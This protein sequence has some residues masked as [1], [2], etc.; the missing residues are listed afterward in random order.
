M[1]KK[2][3][4]TQG[5]AWSWWG[6]LVGVILG[7]VVLAWPRAETAGVTVFNESEKDA[8]ITWLRANPLGFFINCQSQWMRHGARC[9]H[10]SEARKGNWPMGPVKACA[11][12]RDRLAAYARG[13]Q[14]DLCSDCQRLGYV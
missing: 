7:M 1:R 9:P 13:R 4:A 11:L 5:L 6:A 3:M 12:R 2:D 14:V 8:F 10:F